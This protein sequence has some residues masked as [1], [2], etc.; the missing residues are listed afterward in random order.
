MDI[1]VTKPIN[2]DTNHTRVSLVYKGYLGYYL[3]Y[4][5]ITLILY[6]NSKSITYSHAGG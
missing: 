5:L 3:R 6:Q 1:S 2:E 4:A